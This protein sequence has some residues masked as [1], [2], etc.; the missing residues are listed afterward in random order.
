MFSVGLD[1][2]N[3]YAL[4]TTPTTSTIGGVWISNDHTT[5][6]VSQHGNI[7]DWNGNTHDELGRVYNYYIRVNLSGDK[8]IG[9]IHF[10]D[11]PPQVAGQNAPITLKINW[12][13][14]PPYI[15]SIEKV[16]AYDQ[17]DFASFKW[18]KQCLDT[19]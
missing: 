3:A 13:N 12:Y 5:N 18:H 11:S 6:Q 2:H 16:P 19:G 7:L 15:A 10:Y 17:G 9:Y 14:Q 1:I 8:I 4:C